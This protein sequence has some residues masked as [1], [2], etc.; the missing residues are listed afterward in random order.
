MCLE[1]KAP[2]LSERAIEFPAS[3]IRVLVPLAE[4]AAKRGIHIYRVNI[5]QPDLFTPAPIIEQIH[6]FSRKVLSYSPS[7]GEP[8]LLE[9]FQAYYHNLGFQLTRENIMITTGGSEAIVFAFQVVAEP[10]DEIVVPEPCYPNYLGFASMSDIRLI[11]VPTSIDTGFHL[12]SESAIE[13]LVSPRTK[14]FIICNP[15]NPTGTVY[16]REELQMVARIARK[17][18]LFVLSDEVYREFVYDGAIHHSL[19]SFPG[20]SDRAIILD[21][22]SKR[23]SACGARIGALITYREDVIEAAV[24]YGQARLSSPQVA[25]QAVASALTMPAS[26]YRDLVSEYKQRR[27]VVYQ[28]LS[29][30]PGVTCSCPEGAFYL[31]VSLPVDNSESFARWLLSEFEDNGETVMLAPGQGFYVTPGR[32]TREIRIAFVLDTKQMK[33]A[34]SILRVAL[35]KYPGCDRSA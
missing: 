15:N 12:P 33:R 14:A 2:S 9:A 7:Q 32:G 16:R 34:M 23:F 10:G 22:T 27:D 30:I 17:H 3:P 20:L 26:Y 29:T 1:Q 21:S 25:Q 4:E 35:K 19:L 31:I 6:S 24:K 18:D 8:E 5:G 13:A 28:A 11:P